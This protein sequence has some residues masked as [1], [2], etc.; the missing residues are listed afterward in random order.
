MLFRRS[1]SPHIRSTTGPVIDYNGVGEW[2]AAGVQERYRR[3]AIE[4]GVGQSAALEP[5]IHREGN[6]TWVFP[7]LNVFY[8]LIEAGDG[9][10]T[11]IGIQLI[12]EDHFFHFGRTLKI[13][14]ARAL[15][16]ATLTSSQKQRLRKRIVAMLLSGNVP[17]E[18][19]EY[20]RLLR[21]L[22]M[23]GHW[24]EIEAR[25][26]RSNSYVMRHYQ[27]LKQNAP[28]P[29]GIGRSSQENESA[30]ARSLER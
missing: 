11:E 17:A 7:L 16:K 18:F 13:D 20:K 23:A 25:I 9:A 21:D 19:R 4:L 27:W 5:L 8:P 2:S 28:P 3:L 29:R 1:P 15:R 26:D 6:R 14:M 22:G 24:P 12:E 10:A 30:F